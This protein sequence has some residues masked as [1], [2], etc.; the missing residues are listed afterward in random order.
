LGGR[1]RDAL[2][3]YKAYIKIGDAKSSLV[4][5][6]EG[7]IVD[8]AFDLYEGGSMPWSSNG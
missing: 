1:E 4:E 3:A 5:E 2:R 7:S 6:S 8:L